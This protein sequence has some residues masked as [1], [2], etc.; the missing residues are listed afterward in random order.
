VTKVKVQCHEC[1]G[2]GVICSPC[3]YREADRFEHTCGADWETQ[4]TD[5]RGTGKLIVP[6]EVVRCCEY[7]QCLRDLAPQS[8][9]FCEPH[10]IEYREWVATTK[11][12]PLG[13]RTAYRFLADRGLR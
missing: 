6:G 4:C 7:G 13:D 2:T 1:E 5:C 3:S 10:L 8:M 11:V 12:E 9:F